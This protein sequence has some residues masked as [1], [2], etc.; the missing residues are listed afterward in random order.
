MG[1]NQREIQ[2]RRAAQIY[3]WLHDVL[4]RHC[5][6][7][8]KESAEDFYGGSYKVRPIEKLCGLLTS[9]GDEAVYAIAKDNISHPLAGRLLTWWHEHKEYDKTHKYGG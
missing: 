5:D 8:V 4:N 1:P 9:L 6:P 2:M 7:G 3:V